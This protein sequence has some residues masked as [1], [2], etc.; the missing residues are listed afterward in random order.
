MKNVNVTFSLPED[1]N[2][3]LHSFVGKRGLSKF[4]TQAISFALEMEEN[5]LKAA[6]KNAENDPDL[7]ETMNDWDFFSA[8]SVKFDGPN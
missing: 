4:V 2:T 8:S 6:F 7:K 3:L 5:K 1:T